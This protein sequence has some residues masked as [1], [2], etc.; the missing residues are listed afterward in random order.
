MPLRHEDA[1]KAQGNTVTGKSAKGKTFL[2][3]Y[4]RGKKLTQ[5]QAILAKCYECMGGYVD[6]KRDC[7]INGCPLY[8]LMPYK[9]GDEA[10]A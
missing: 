8:P 4:A 3:Q 7:K 5:R 6:G 9:G 1:K 2:E 10:A